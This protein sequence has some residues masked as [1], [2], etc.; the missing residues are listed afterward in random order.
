MKIKVKPSAKIKKRYFLIKAKSRRV[1]E[2]AILDYIGILGW[3]KAMPV[4]VESKNSK[5]IILSVNRKE[6]DN[7]RA[8]FEASSS[9]INIARVSGTI[10]GLKKKRRGKNEN[11]KNK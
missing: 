10:K 1:V 8:S 9:M 7:V 6:I 2:K 5:N 4:F 11:K 3:A